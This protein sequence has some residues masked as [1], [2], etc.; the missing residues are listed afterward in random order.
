L[1]KGWPFS[2]GLSQGVPMLRKRK[3]FIH[4]NAK[5]FIVRKLNISNKDDHI[6]ETYNSKTSQLA[7][8][9]KEAPRPQISRTQNQ[10]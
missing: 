2:L 7:I 10:K 5:N 4:K 3:S 8:M 6:N 1:Q 9:K